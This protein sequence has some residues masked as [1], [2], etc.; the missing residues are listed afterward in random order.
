MYRCLTDLENSILG[1]WEEYRKKERPI[2]FF[3]ND[4]FNIVLIHQVLMEHKSHQTVLKD[5]LSFVINLFNCRPYLVEQKTRETL[6]LPLNELIGEIQSFESWVVST[7]IGFEWHYYKNLSRK[8]SVLRYR[9][10]Q[11]FLDVVFS[12]SESFYYRYTYRISGILLTENLKLFATK[13]FGLGRSTR[14]IKSGRFIK[15]FN[16]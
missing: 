16:N 15:C 11:D 12:G 13:G 9:L 1:N 3:T 4:I 8:S 6:E 14:K 5:S 10:G 2:N 7:Q